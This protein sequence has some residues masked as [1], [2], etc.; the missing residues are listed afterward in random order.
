M[1]TVMT[2]QTRGCLCISK[3]SQDEIVTYSICHVDA[4]MFLITVLA[5]SCEN[6]PIVGE[7]LQCLAMP[8]VL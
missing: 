3:S 8:I 1:Q 2:D 5:V 4:Q 6:L 7:K